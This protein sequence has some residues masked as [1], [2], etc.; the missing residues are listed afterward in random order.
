MKPISMIVSIL[1]VGLLFALFSQLFNLAP[2]DDTDPP[3]GRSG[4]II[5]TDHLTG[6]QYLRS[7]F[8]GLTPRMDGSRRHICEDKRLEPEGNL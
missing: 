1:I 3:G 2:K 5:Y 4:L 8:G 7:G 6:C